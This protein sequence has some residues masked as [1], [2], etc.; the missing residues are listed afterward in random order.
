[1]SYRVRYKAINAQGKHI[2]R[3]EDIAGNQ[4]QHVITG[5]M[6]N[7]T[8]LLNIMARNMYGESSYM[9]ESLKVTT[10]STY[11]LHV[12][13]RTSVNTGNYVPINCDERACTLL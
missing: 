6:P 5:L 3:Y 13:A 1:M 12:P 10:L 4:T 7:T 11:N 8:Y 9:P 2:Y